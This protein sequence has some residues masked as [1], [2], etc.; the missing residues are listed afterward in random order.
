M[1][2][3]NSNQK[4]LGW[5]GKMTKKKQLVFDSFLRKYLFNQV[6]FAVK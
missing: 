5:K 3:K 4:H 6:N 2:L 1:I